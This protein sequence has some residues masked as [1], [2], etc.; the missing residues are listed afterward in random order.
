MSSQENHQATINRY[1][2]GEIEES[3][4]KNQLASDVGLREAY[5]LYQKDIGAIRK[6]AKEQL[7]KKAALLLNKHENKQAKFF[8]LKRVL[9]IAAAI[10][11]LITSIFL[12][13]NYLQ[14]KSAEDIFADYFELAAPTNE[15]NATPQAQNWNA[16][17]T[18]YVN[19]DYRKS[20]ELLISL[21][22]QKDFPYPERGK[23]YL[24]L[25]QLMDNKPQ[26]AIDNFGRVASESSY[27]QEA[28]WYRALAF[29]KMGDVERAKAVFQKIANQPRHFKE[30]AAQVILTK[31]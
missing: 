29:L 25:S 9:Q 3:D 27:F 15:R 13:Q 8:S 26:Q 6:L 17:M 23:L 12:I 7:R 11:L 30:K 19:Q 10:A 18:A 2:N 24:G 4:F 16:A 14:P 21:V 22:N 20:I 28:E 31:I 1:H 5:E